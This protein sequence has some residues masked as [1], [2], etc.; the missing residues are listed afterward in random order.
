MRDHERELIAALV[1]GRLDD[2]SEARALVASSPEL[3]E[4]YQAQMLAYRALTGAGTASLTE[5]ERAELHRDTWTALRHQPGDPARGSW[6]LR[7]A[8]VAAGLFVVVGLATVLSTSGG[9][10]AGGFAEIAADTADRDLAGEDDTA[11]DGAETFEDAG[12]STTAAASESPASAS[13]ESVAIFQRESDLIRQGIFTERLHSVSESE[14]A[15][16]ELRNCIEE[17]GLDGYRII[18][19]LAEPEGTSEAAGGDTSSLAVAIPYEGQLETAP[20]A[21]VDLDICEAV[22]VDK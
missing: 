12:A 4:E 22:Y 5:A 21:F 19:T 17:A 15:Y 16:G 1:E 11:S 18:A 10:D 2:E 13:D 6:Y 3:Q 8:A 14:D 20:I 7:V 9:P